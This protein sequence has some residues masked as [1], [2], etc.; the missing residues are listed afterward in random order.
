M[1]QR[2]A[3][4]YLTDE[5]TVQNTMFYGKWSLD[6]EQNSMNKTENEKNEAGSFCVTN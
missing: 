4:N 3:Q 5:L 6:L 1:F 2:V